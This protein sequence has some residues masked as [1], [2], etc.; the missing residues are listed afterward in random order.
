MTISERPTYARTRV[1]LA[2]DTLGT[3]AS[4]PPPARSYLVKQSLRPMRSARDFARA[5]PVPGRCCLTAPRIG[6][7]VSLTVTG[8]R[9][10]TTYTYYALAAQDNVLGRSGPRAQV[11]VRTR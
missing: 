7:R 9:P 1:T 5:D 4:R 3:D 6:G 8:L 11:V 2:F 10:R